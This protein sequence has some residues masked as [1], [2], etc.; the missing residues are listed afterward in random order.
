MLAWVKTPRFKEEDLRRF[1]VADDGTVTFEQTLLDG[2]FGRL[3]G[4]VI[5]PDGALYVT[6]SNGTTDRIV[7]VRRSG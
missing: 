1:S 2:R 6:S 4:V 7:R 5:G 3:R